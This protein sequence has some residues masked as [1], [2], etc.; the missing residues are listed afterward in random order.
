MV[1]IEMSKGKQKI[2]MIPESQCKEFLSYCLL[3]QVVGLFS[4]FSGEMEFFR[5]FSTVK[6]DRQEGGIRKEN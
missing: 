2:F 6:R 5:Q 3:L 4:G 1:K